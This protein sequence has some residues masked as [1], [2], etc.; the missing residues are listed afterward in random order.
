MRTSA[1][2]MR[3][4]KMTNIQNVTC[5]IS[6]VLNLKLLTSYLGGTLYYNDNDIRRKEKKKRYKIR[7]WRQFFCWFRI[8]SI[9][10]SLSRSLWGQHSLA[11]MAKCFLSIYGILIAFNSVKRSIFQFSYVECANIIIDFDKYEAI[12]AFTQK[13]FH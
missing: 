7:K 2:E 6:R 1:R 12:E 10:L 5:A 8:F 4:D 13:C 11:S 3:H 9:Y